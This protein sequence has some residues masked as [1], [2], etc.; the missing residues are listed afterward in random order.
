[1]SDELVYNPAWKPDISLVVSPHISTVQFARCQLSVT[2]HGLF[3]T[4]L[5]RTACRKIPHH[6]VL[7][8]NLLRGNL[9][10]GGYVTSGVC[11]SVCLSL[12]VSSFT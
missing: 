10:Q 8:V 12:S 2:V 11:L 7:S 6:W 1:L 9:H 4:L 5:G 3:G